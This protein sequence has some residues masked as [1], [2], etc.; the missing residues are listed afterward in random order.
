MKSVPVDRI[1]DVLKKHGIEKV[2]G[3]R[4]E[5]LKIGCQLHTLSEDDVVY[6]ASPSTG[7]NRAIGRLS[8]CRLSNL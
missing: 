8:Q 3:E 2:D 7:I 5:M 1:N 4:R 6:I